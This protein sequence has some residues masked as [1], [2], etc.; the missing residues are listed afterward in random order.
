MDQ[1][2]LIVASS[3]TLQIAH[4]MFEHF[5]F[6]QT[7][8]K[9]LGPQTYLTFISLNQSLFGLVTKFQAS[10]KQIPTSKKVFDITATI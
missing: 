9:T 8:G 3:Q 7:S 1:D 5:F 10:F 4:Q 2:R 6:I